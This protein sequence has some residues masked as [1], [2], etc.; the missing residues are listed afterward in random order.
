MLLAPR[1]CYFVTNSDGA[2]CVVYQVLTKN[3]SVADFA[4]R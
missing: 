1:D 4:K 2:E 3:N